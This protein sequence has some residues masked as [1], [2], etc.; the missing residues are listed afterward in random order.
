M[1][2]IVTV[3][4]CAGAVIT[5]GLMVCTGGDCSTEET[6]MPEL[7]WMISDTNPSTDELACF[8]LGDVRVKDQ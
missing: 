6:V 5:Q 3:W 7:K 2:E 1:A 4:I 8:R